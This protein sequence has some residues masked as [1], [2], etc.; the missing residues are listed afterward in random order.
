MQM[1]DLKTTVEPSVRET[2]VKNMM[3]SVPC[4][5]TTGEGFVDPVGF[6]DPS[7]RF[8]WKLP[9][10]VKRQTAY[11]LEV[12][13]GWN[14]GWVESGQS[15]LVPYGGQPLKSREQAEWRVRFRDESGAE[16]G[17]SDSAR[18][19]MGLLSYTEWTAQW[20][21]PAEGFDPAAEAVT[22]LR[23]GF[24]VNRRVERARL[25]V[26]ARGLFEVHVNG[27]KVGDDAF[28]PGWTSYHHRL[29]TL[30]YDV[31]GM[32]QSGENAI[33]ILLGTGWYS[34]RLVGWQSHWRNLYGSHP[35]VLLQLEIV[36]SDGTE[37]IVSGGDWKATVDGPVRSSSIYDGEEYDARLE[38]PGWD[39]PGFDDSRW[40]GVAVRPV[41]GTAALTPKPFVPVRKTGE[42]H[43]LSV[44][45]PVL[46]RFVFDLGQNMVGWAALKM[47][48]EEGRTVTLRFA[49]ML[50]P[51]GTLYTDNYRSAK[52]TDTYTASA[53]GMAVWE[54]VFTFHGF[55]YV[56]LSGL[57]GG[58]APDLTW[59][60][61]VVLHSD[62][63]R[64]G[65][66]ESSSELLNRLYSNI[67]WGQRGNFLEIP[68]DCPQRDERLG[69]TGDAQVFCPTAMFNYDCH[70]FFKSWLGSM[71]TEQTA[72]GRIPF[73]IPATGL[74]AGSPGW[75]DAAVIIP[76]AVYVRTGDSGV[77]AENF[78]MMQRLVSTYRSRAKEYL[79]PECDGFGDWLQPHAENLKG[80]TPLPLL[81]S[82]F[83]AYDAQLTANVADVLGRKDIAQQYAAEAAAVRTA[84]AQHYFNE[85]G[86][87]RNAPET[88]TAYLLSIAFNLIPAGLQKKAAGHLVE[89]IRAADGH[90]RTGFLGTPFIASV[91]D[92]MGYT[93]IA[94]SVLFKETYPSWFYSIHQGA[95]TMWERWN[96][97]SHTDGFGKVSMNS[98][99]HYAYGAIGQWMVERIAGLAPDPRHPGYKHFFVNPAIGGPLTSAK[100]ELETPFGT[101]SSAWEKSGSTVVMNVVVPPNASATIEFPNGRPS[102]TVSAGIYRFELEMN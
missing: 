38:M 42:L 47:P 11:Q 25:Y 51:D 94:F 48:V 73:V 75:Q 24:S 52:S 60:K 70:A 27:R 82:A 85:D 23:R 28:T 14:S 87:I 84:F 10:G 9:D 12:S 35:E 6:H 30:T 100:A 43:P 89:L 95:T 32:L 65:K 97:Y 4:H 18:L 8:S 49:E 40:S 29:D 62:L 96:S 57:P 55:R 93:D 44:T 36:Y 37:R 88:Q 74:G 83:Y 1:M 21:F 63:P 16:S 79:L 64:I 20:I 98:F 54:P 81:G 101:A 91:L 31:T 17:W 7:P 39:K 72:D 86:K 46:G 3:S 102:E 92:R 15:V 2:P 66:F 80:D 90:L 69:W 78:E 71:R 61:G 26:T 53:A 50:N 41:C 45:Q 59:V 68:T 5:L 34:G 56:E 33:G 58:A 13:N 19:E 99:N 76:W 67:V 22:Y 77:L